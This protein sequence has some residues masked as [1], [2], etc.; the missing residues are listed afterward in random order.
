M[1]SKKIIDLE[2]VKRIQSGNIL[3]SDR[4]TLTTDEISAIIYGEGYYSSSN[5]EMSPQEVANSLEDS[6]VLKEAFAILREHKKNS[7]QD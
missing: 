4:E 2:Q 6:D 5:G 1:A 7:C 3:P